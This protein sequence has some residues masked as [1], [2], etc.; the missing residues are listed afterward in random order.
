M[1]GTVK[2]PGGQ[3]GQHASPWSCHQ[4]PCGGHSMQRRSLEPRVETG[5]QEEAASYPPQQLSGPRPLQLVRPC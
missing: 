3:P 4:R 1:L 5:L 2:A